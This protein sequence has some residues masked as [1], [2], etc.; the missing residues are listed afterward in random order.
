[1]SGSLLD[2]L[3]RAGDGATAS[4]TPPADAPGAPRLELTRTFV[5]EALVWIE[6]LNRAVDAPEA[7]RLAVSGSVLHAMLPVLIAYRRSH[8]ARARDL[9]SWIWAAHAAA[10]GVVEPGE[11]ASV[12]PNPAIEPVAPTLD[13]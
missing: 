12:L 4:F 13:D 7:V 2:A 3:S 5:R 9:L 11:L 10:F 8:A 1:M 6:T